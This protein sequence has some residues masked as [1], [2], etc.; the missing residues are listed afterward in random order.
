MENN[1]KQNDENCIINENENIPEKSLDSLENIINKEDIINFISSTLD[2][3]IHNNKQMK[4]KQSRGPNEPLYSK[5][6]PVLSLNNYLIRTMKYTESENNTL[7]AAY[8]YIIKLIKKENF[9]L[10]INNVYRL[11]LG[12][13]VLAK[14]FLE[15]IKYDNS[16]YC[17]IGGISNQELN[18][19]EYSLFT[20]IEFNLNLQKE[21]IDIIYEQISKTLPKSRLDEI[22][23]K[24]IYK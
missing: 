9:V 4:K 17:N 18:M 20:R 21:H 8:L 7:I 1:K 3:I 16:Y 5:N 23:K 11:I 10:G 12:S 13:V 15:D 19:I 14:K 24:K 2:S 6:I 22:S